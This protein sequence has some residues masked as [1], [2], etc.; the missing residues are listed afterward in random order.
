MA[1]YWVG[2]AQHWQ[3]SALRPWIFWCGTRAVSLRRATQQPNCISFFVTRV[4]TNPP[5]NPKAGGD[6]SWCQNIGSGNPSR[7]IFQ[8]VAVALYI[9]GSGSSSTAERARIKLNIGHGRFRCSSV[10][11]YMITRYTW[12]E[13]PWQGLRRRRSNGGGL[14]SP[15]PADPGRASAVIVEYPRLLSIFDQVV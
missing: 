7:P 3:E 13:G 8:Q 9:L 5:A 10:A 11:F 4:P 1:R 12:P 6:E 2:A 15:T 14:F